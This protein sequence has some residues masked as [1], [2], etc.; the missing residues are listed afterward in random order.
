MDV[1]IY[2]KFANKKK[3]K[4]NLKKKKNKKKQENELVNLEI[5]TQEQSR[6]EDI[7][8]I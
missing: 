7:N 5:S 2:K 1:A 4:I 8:I 6:R 3:R